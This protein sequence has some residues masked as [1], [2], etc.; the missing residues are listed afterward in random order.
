MTRATLK[1]RVKPATVNITGARFDL[2]ALN[3]WTLDLQAMAD[4]SRS[5]AVAA[6]PMIKPQSLRPKDV[7]EDGWALSLAM[8]KAYHKSGP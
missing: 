1:S 6:R 8:M 3:A 7:G 5:T 4:S 2:M